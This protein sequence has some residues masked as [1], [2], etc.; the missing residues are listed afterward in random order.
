MKKT[1]LVIALIFFI[2]LF[3]INPAFAAAPSAT[4]LSAAE[5]YTEDTPL[6]LIDIV[7]S[8]ADGGSLTATL[9]LSNPAAGSLTTATVGATTSTFSGGVWTANGPIADINA[10]LAGVSF[11]PASNFNSDFSINTR[12]EDGTA[13][14]NGTK[15]FTGT[16]VNDAPILD[17][18]RSPGMG[19]V[20]ED[21]SA[22]TGAVGVLVSTLVDFVPPSGQVDNVTDIDSGAS[23]GIAIINSNPSLTCY[24]SINSGATWNVLG[25]PSDSAARLLAANGT[26]RV[27]CQPPADFNGFYA[28][29]ITF[30]AWDQTAGTNGATADTT[31]NGGATAFS[32][33]SDLITLTISA[34]ND[35]PIL[36]ASKSPALV[37]TYLNEGVPVGLMGTSVATL[38][39][40][41]D[42]PGGLDNLYDVDGGSSDG[43]AV[44][45]INGSLTCYYTL[46]RGGSWSPIGAVS[47]TSARLLSIASSNRIY[48]TP[49]MDVSGTY[50]NAITFRAWDRST[51]TDGTLQSTATNGG[52]SAFSSATDTASLTVFTSPNNVPIAVTDEYTVEHDSLTTVLFVLENDTDADNDSLEITSIN[53]LDSTLGTMQITSPPN[54][55]GYTPAEGFC[56]DE[57]YEYTIKDGHGG[58]SIGTVIMHV[59]GCDTV[60]VA[61]TLTLP[62]TGT[63]YYN[64][65]LL[66]VTFTLPELLFA[67]SLTLTF[68]PLT[69]TSI[70]LHLRDAAPGT[71]T[72]S[73]DTR[74]GI[75][76]V[77]EVVGTNSESI[78]PG[79]YSVIISYQDFMGNAA[80]TASS[81]NVTIA[82][83]PPGSGS[84]GSVILFGCRD[85]RAI[86]YNA[87]SANNSL[88]CTYTTPPVSPTEVFHFKRNLSLGISGADVVILQQFLNSHGF[89]ISLIGPGSKGKETNLFGNKTKTALMKYQKA[90]GIDAI[91]ILGPKTRMAIEQEMSK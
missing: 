7:A 90:K 53:P 70:V 78:P 4:N 28:D 27:Y 38:I 91:G 36:D 77:T 20:S 60:T 71:N 68:V 82:T 76:G 42:M 9:T 45:D 37:T 5:T 48:C 12:V 83:P 15:F 81:T 26:S 52:T 13:S 50:A 57:Q 21:S 44:T 65:S 40:S 54:A 16:V 23:L 67:G 34:V 51:G 74:S 58:S 80:A 69:G 3:F 59:V 73:F 18:T 35:A 72:F 63:T 17:A 89:P 1:S 11:V 43:I 10:L 86:N 64:T 25:S 6:N 87:S 14:A 41:T 30:R 19:S 56:E 31:T 79:N 55:L 22:P 29:A 8:D 62:A 39:D 66:T 84:S 49:G 85:P 33:S 24:Y 32:A 61:P 2:S 75:S 47:N 88:A 46:N